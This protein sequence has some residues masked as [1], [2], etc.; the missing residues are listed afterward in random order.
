MRCGDSVTHPQASSRDMLHE[1]IVGSSDNVSTGCGNLRSCGC[2]ALRVT[3]VRQGTRRERYRI[4]FSE[5][6]LEA[7]LWIEFVA[8]SN[9]PCCGSRAA[10][11]LAAGS[12][13]L[14]AL[15]ATR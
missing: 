15:A 7:R 14:V 1:L 9:G 3:A 11:G 4:A 6:C 8:G 13:R 10:C 12:V 5:G 2:Q